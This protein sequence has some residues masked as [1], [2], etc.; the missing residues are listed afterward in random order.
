MSRTEND[1][2]FTVRTWSTQ[3]RESLQICGDVLPMA[4]GPL[5]LRN[6]KYPR[7]FHMKVKLV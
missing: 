4:L 1:F 2:N 3:T 5:S 7:P 6:I